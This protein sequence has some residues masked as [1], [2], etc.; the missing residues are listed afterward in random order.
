[1]HPRADSC[2]HVKVHGTVNPSVLPG[3]QEALAE[4]IDGLVDHYDPR[5]N[6]EHGHLSLRAALTARRASPHLAGIRVPE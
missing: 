2:N 3:G 1:M 6:A 5:L 4:A